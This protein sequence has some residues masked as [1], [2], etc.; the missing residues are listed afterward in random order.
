MI[1]DSLLAASLLL[2][3]GAFAARPVRDLWERRAGVVHLVYSD[4][5]RVTSRPASAF[6]R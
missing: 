5:Q 6:S 3:A 4:H 2:L 1:A